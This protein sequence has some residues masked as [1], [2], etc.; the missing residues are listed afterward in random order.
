MAVLNEVLPGVADRLRANPL[1]RTMTF[2][3]MAKVSDGMIS[4]DVLKA[5]DEKLKVL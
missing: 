4:E 3:T 1:S 2:T 5:L